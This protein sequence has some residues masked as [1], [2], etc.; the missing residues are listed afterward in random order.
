MFEFKAQ[1]LKAVGWQRSH[2]KCLIFV[3]ISTGIDPQKGELKLDF[4][5]RRVLLG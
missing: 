1:L 4:Q 3:T 2:L 5:G